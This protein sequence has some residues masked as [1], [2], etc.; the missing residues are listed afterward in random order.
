MPLVGEIRITPSARSYE[1]GP[2]DYEYFGD[3]F[4]RLYQLV[5]RVD[6]DGCD[7]RDV[8]LE[9]QFDSLSHLT[10]ISYTSD[11]LGKEFIVLARQ[12]ALTLQL[13]AFT[14]EDEDY[15]ISEIF[16]D[17]GDRSVVLPHLLKLRLSI[18]SGAYV[19]RQPAPTGPAQFPC[20]RH[21]AL[22]G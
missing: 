22:V 19:S 21:L 10:H 12:N 15:D 9:T 17:A 3:L 16:T 8:S 13:F 1:A 6:L 11:G 2:I 18:D 7:L 20:L 4:L 5:G 14:S